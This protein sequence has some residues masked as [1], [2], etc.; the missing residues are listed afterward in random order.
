MEMQGFLQA[1]D[2]GIVSRCFMEPI[3]NHG[4]QGIG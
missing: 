1:G 3:H 2:T 4:Q